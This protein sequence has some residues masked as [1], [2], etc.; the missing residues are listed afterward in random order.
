MVCCGEPRQDVTL[1]PEGYLQNVHEFRPAFYPL[2]IVLF[3][4]YD[5]IRKPDRRAIEEKRLRQQ[6][7]LVEKMAKEKEE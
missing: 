1:K 5:I 7:N 4:H 6:G 3:V 2:F